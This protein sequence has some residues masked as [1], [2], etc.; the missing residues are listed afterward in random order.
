MSEEIKVPEI[1]PVPPP[2]I[3]EDTTPIVS[4][5]AW[6]NQIRAEWDKFVSSINGLLSIPLVGWA[7]YAVLYVIFGLLFGLLVTI[8]DL[9]DAL[10]NGIADIINALYIWWKNFT[11]AV[12]ERYQ[13][14]WWKAIIDIAVQF[15]LMYALEKALNIPAIKQIWDIFVSVISKINSYLMNL[16]DRITSTF[17][18]VADYFAKLPSELNPFVRTLFREEIGFWT[19]Q[20]TSALKT[21]E[22]GLLKMIS[23]IDNKLTE[24]S[25]KIISTVNKLL[26]EWKEFKKELEKKAVEAT[27]GKLVWMVIKMA[28]PLSIEVYGDKEKTK[29]I[30]K[31]TFGPSQIEATYSTMDQKTGEIYVNLSNYFLDF[32]EETFDDKTEVGKRLSSAINYAIEV[33]DEL[34]KRDG[35]ILSYRGLLDD[36]NAALDGLV[37]ELESLQKGGK[38]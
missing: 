35:I 17:R 4:Y 18:S 23:D 34:W 27:V 37:E 19:N 10:W 32:V 14:N 16:R 5:I 3:E 31:Y 7:L 6:G 9:I 30:S 38:K 15:L 13:G 29:L 26:E 22:S 24:K 2:E 1:N 33:T 20:M 12:Q 28:S 8:A 36:A 21:V 11:K 25:E